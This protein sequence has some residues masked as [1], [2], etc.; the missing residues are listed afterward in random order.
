MRQDG[1][2]EGR[3]C[4]SQIQIQ[5]QSQAG[6]TGDRTNWVTA[7]TTECSRKNDFYC[8]R[9]AGNQIGFFVT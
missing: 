3:R 8:K 2:G 9:M 4:N 5:I 6:D 7:L 1:E